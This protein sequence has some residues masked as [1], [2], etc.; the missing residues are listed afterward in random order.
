M[1][2]GIGE[3]KVWVRQ[4]T[5]L[6]RSI[7]P[8]AATLAVLGAVN[9]P[10][11]LFTYTSGP[12][13]FPG[14][15]LV[16]GT[17][18]ATL[19]SVPLA[20][21]YTLYGWAMPRSGGDYVFVSRVL[22]PVL[23]FVEN[24]GL[25]F[26]SLFFIGFAANFAT[27]LAISPSLL[28]LGTVTSNQGMVNLANTLSQPQYVVIIG[29]IVIALFTAVMLKGVKATFLIT[30]IFTTLALIGVLVAIVLLASS[31]NASF[32]S[33]FGRFGSY[34]NITA[35]AHSAGYSPVGTSVLLATLG[36]M[37]LVYLTTGFANTTTYYA[38]E[39]R[40]V[41]RSMFTSQVLVAI[42]SG[43]ILTVVAWFSV[44]V[45]GYDFLGSISYL[46]ANGSAA[47]PFSFPPFFNLL[48]S[49][50]TT[51]QAV[52]WLLAITFVAAI[53][54]PILPVL[55]AV[56]RSIFAWSFD[57]AVPTRFARVSNR[58][59]TPVF[60]VLVM[61]AIWAVTLI[62]Y[63]Y[64][65]PLF[66]TLLAG[67]TLAENLSLMVI[68]IAA[69]VFPFRKHLWD[70]SPAKIKAA[71]LPLISVCG[72]ISLAFLLLITYFLVENPLYGA[73]NSTVYAGTI[74]V[75]VLAAVIYSASRYFNRKHG[76]DISLAFKEIPPE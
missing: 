3:P 53:L 67:A 59:H 66:L 6:V 33:G 43:L 22:N 18:L 62:I 46:Q 1:L 47:Y 74:A 42:I 17:L 52:L 70:Q 72:V 63:T 50:L 15:D 76:L 25:M 23:G 2:A 61:N 31:S 12:F 29:L 58:L 20:L 19:L 24:F 14:S 11:G 75:F 51:N 8:L 60:A 27:T 5:G 49:M 48:A 35:T 4:A 39:V 65:P 30:G 71:G 44:S 45:F 26:W 54:A 32:A 57:R 16:V 64:G 10:L 21:M 36:I 37:P 34:G 9:I 7:S 13:L 28:I 41:K 56:S 40:A 73:N 68:A 55:M 38:G 69:I